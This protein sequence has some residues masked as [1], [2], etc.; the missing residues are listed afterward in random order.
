VTVL[1]AYVNYQGVHRLIKVKACR[2]REATR[3]FLESLLDTEVT[4]R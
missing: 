1:F 4:A 2:D 3:R